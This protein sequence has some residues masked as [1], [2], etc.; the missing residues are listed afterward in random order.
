MIEILVTLII[1]TCTNDCNSGLENKFVLLHSYRWGQQEWSTLNKLSFECTLIIFKMWNRARTG[2]EA[3]QICLRVSVCVCICVW[4]YMCVDR[5]WLYW[6]GF[7]FL[8]KNL[9]AEHNLSRLKQY[10]IH[11]KQNKDI[12]T[13]V[14][15]SDGPAGQ[16]ACIIH[17]MV[18][19]P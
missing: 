2:L 9:E 7:R 5:N 3:W 19:L 1:T 14:L 11:S 6:L 15:N 8:D 13:P 16:T 17:L 12:R 10:W 4:V 18:S